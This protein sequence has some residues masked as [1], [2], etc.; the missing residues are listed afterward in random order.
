M[1]KTL[2]K[3][4][5]HDSSIRHA[6]LSSPK[7]SSSSREPTILHG[8][9]TAAKKPRIDSKSNGTNNTSQSD[10]LRTGAGDFSG[11]AMSQLKE[12]ITN[13]QRQLSRKDQELLEKD[14]K[15]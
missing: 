1:K 4:K 9:V 13:L 10:M 2:A 6:S 12:Q 7:S 14:K 11:A 5:Q 15:V 8:L 3:A